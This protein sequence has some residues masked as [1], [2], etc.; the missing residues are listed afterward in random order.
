MKS[1]LNEIEE[2][3]VLQSLL[4]LKYIKM[5]QFLEIFYDTSQVYMKQI[6]YLKIL[7]CNSEQNVWQKVRK[8]DK[9]G[10]EQKI[11]ISPFV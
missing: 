1:V 8:W 3:T 11:L 7:L 10:E 9:I 5:K 6:N 2:E 4:N